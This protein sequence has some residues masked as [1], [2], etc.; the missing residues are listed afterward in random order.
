MNAGDPPASQEIKSKD[1]PKQKEDTPLLQSFL[2]TLASHPY[3]STV[4]GPKSVSQIQQAKLGS[5]RFMPAVPTIPP[6]PLPPLPPAKQH[7]LQHTAVKHTAAPAFSVQSDGP[8]L[9]TVI[10][11]RGTK[12]LNLASST[13]CTEVPVGTLAKAPFRHL[14]GAPC[15]GELT[16]W[17]SLCKLQE[18][19]VPTGS[20]QGLKSRLHA[21]FS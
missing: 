2:W 12:V 1:A 19:F 4:S 14:W 15:P 5:T 21:P 16:S 17:V 11:D 3:A 10:N 9:H 8:V 13:A 20:G 6:P 7:K 18:P